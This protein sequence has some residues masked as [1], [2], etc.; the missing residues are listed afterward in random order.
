MLEAS[1]SLTGFPPTLPHFPVAPLIQMKTTHRACVAH[2][3]CSALA[4]SS[5]SLHSSLFLFVRRLRPCSAASADLFVFVFVSLF[6]L[7]V[8]M[9]AY[10]YLSARETSPIRVLFPMNLFIPVSLWFSWSNSVPRVPLVCC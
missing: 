10:R 8:I 6:S 9:A 2:G 4:H 1:L 3:L 7:F 5:P